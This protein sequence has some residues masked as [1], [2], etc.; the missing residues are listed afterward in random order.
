MPTDS[1]RNRTPNPRNSAANKLISN[2][3]KTTLSFEFNFGR[4]T[5]NT[6]NHA[7]KNVPIPSRTVAKCGNTAG[8]MGDT[9]LD[10]DSIF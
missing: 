5:S 9:N 4:E 1:K 8:L 7:V 6:K 10:I 2:S 3:L